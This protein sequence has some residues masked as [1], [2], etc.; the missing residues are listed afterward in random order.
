MGFADGHV[1]FINENVSSTVWSAIGTRNGGEV[2][3]YVE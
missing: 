2:V 1:L 3:S